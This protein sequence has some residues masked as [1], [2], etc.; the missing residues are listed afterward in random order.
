MRTFM[1]DLQMATVRCSHGRPP[2]EDRA[3]FLLIRRAKWTASVVDG[4]PT[5][6]RSGGLRVYVAK[7]CQHDGG[8]GTGR[9]LNE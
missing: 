9:Q 2:A 6:G 8:V 1:T 7:F 5:S 3:Q 4:F